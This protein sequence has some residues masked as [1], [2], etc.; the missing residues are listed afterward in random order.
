MDT[1]ANN[2][3]SYVFLNTVVTWLPF[4]PGEGC[5]DERVDSQLDKGGKSHVGYTLEAIFL[6]NPKSLVTR[7]WKRRE[8][9]CL[10][11]VFPFGHVIFLSIEKNY[12]QKKVRTC[13]SEEKNPV[14]WP[15]K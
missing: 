7:V 11:H 2:L 8:G 13:S 1:A 4:G 3:Y 5:V 9:I 12:T 14:Q 10:R 6:G 15:F